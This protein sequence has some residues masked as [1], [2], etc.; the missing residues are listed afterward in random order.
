MAGQ[1]IGVNGVR[2][3]VGAQGVGVNGVHRKVKGG[4]VG[5]NGVA[6]SFTKTTQVNF[7]G[8]NSSAID[9][10]L[11]GSWS[12]PWPVAYASG[13]IRFGYMSYD[14]GYGVY[15][16][17]YDVYGYAGNVANDQGKVVFGVSGEGTFRIPVD[18]T[19][20]TGEGTAILSAEMVLTI[21]RYGFSAYVEVKTSAGTVRFADG[22]GTVDGFEYDI[23]LY[24][25]EED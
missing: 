2:R 15:S 20:F 9:S 23:T 16:N 12:A 25:S 3:K 8:E 17:G 24:E 10:D 13:Y 4:W 1:Y 18:K 6:R 11:A 22:D 19:K 7:D 21:S 14:G 5:V